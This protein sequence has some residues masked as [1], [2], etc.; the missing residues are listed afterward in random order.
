MPTMAGA[1]RTRR[2][3]D[4]AGRLRAEALRWQIDEMR[5]TRHRGDQ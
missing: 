1:L 5:Y 3:V 4:E 2:S